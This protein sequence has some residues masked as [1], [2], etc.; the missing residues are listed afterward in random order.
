MLREA[1]GFFS[2]GQPLVC[3][4]KK[5]RRAQRT[6]AAPALAEKYAG[7]AGAHTLNNAALT[8]AGLL[9]GKGS[10][11]KTIALTVMGGVDTDCT[12]A[13]AGSIVGAM[14]GARRLPRKWTRPLG[15]RAESYIIGRRRWRSSDIARRFCRIAAQVWDCY[16]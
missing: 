10:Y 15:D 12:G 3:T 8:V 2:L 9:Y 7:M 13:T 11:E 4:H 1:K 14:L 6:G 5:S 16:A